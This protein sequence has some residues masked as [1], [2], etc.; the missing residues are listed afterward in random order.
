MN[1]ITWSI[2]QFDELITHELYQILQLRSEV[3]VVE[4]NCVFQDMDNKDQVSWHLM[5]WHND[6][7][8]AYTRL[9][10]AGISFAEISIGRVVTSPKMRK[11]GTGRL[12][13]EKS[14]ATAYNIFGKKPIRIGAQLYLKRFY[15]SFGF[16]QS[17]EIYI[18]DGIEHIEMLLT[19][20]S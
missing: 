14:I 11:S 8:A 20:L 1:T 6:L 12:L 18:E 3:F 17:S 9:V 16:Q 7:L 2:K 4:Q 5:G 13:M 15:E 19:D 10:P